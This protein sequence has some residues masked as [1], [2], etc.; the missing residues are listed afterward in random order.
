MSKRI[1]VVDDHAPT[2][3]FMRAVLKGEKSESFDVVEA[4]NG[5]ACL[6]AV[7][8]G[9]PFDLI[10]LDVEMPDMDGYAVCRTIREWA[11]KTPVVFVTAKGEFK[12]FRAG[13]DAG[14]DSY[15]AKPIS[16]ASL[17]SMVNVFTHL[18]RRGDP[19]EKGGQ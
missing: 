14:A 9:P 5:K 13:G 16:K 10:F 6:A 8:E 7:D 17:L 12:D 18:S 11:I 19:A 2:R 15:I 3:A 4:P 1:L